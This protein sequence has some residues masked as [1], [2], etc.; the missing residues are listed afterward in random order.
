MRNARFAAGACWVVCARPTEP[1]QGAWRGGLIPQSRSTRRAPLSLALCA[2]GAAAPNVVPFGAS[3]EGLRTFDRSHL[4]FVFMG[5]AF[6]LFSCLRLRVCAPRARCPFR[7]S[8]GFAAGVPAGGFA[9]RCGET[10]GLRCWSLL[11]LPASV[12]RGWGRC[13]L[14]CASSV[15]V[16]PIGLPSRVCIALCMS[17]PSWCRRSIVRRGSWWL[18][19]GCWCASRSVRTLR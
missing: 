8:R 7:A 10:L 13:P 14:S 11:V 19:W 18:A 15:P 16:V 12:L 4:F 3:N 2:A 6:G 17:S 1:P 5:A 9:V